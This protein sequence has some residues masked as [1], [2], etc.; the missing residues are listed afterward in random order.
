MVISA[1]LV[2]SLL[3]AI[4]GYTGYAIPGTP[5]H[6]RTLPHDELA[7]KVCGRPCRIIGFTTLE[8]DILLDDSLMVGTDQTATSILVHELTHFLQ[9]RS[10]DGRPSASCTAWRERE[11]EAY[12]VQYRWLRDHAPNLRTLSLETVKLGPNPVLPECSGNA[13][14]GTL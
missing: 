13:A 8:G 12:D 10:E 11:R 3:V 9:I 1:K 2:A 4:S 7:E 14:H 5:P 6:I